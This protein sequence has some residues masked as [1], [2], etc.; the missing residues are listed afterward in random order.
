M[1]LRLRYSQEVVQLCTFLSGPS[2]TEIERGVLA[3]ADPEI[4]TSGEEPI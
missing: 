4:G 1:V 2:N 3:G